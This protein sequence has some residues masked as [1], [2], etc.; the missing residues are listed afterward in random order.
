MS[1]NTVNSDPSFYKITVV[2]EDTNVNVTQGITKVV[3]VVSQGP[4]GPAGTGGGGSETDPIFAA[5]SASF[6]TTGSNTFRGA[7]IIS[8]S[9]QTTILQVHAANSEPWAFGIYNDT[10]SSTIQ[11]LAGWIDATGEAN[12]GTEVNKPLRIYTSASYNNPTLTIS[13]SGVTV[14][15]GGITGSLYG[16][17]SWATSASEAITAS[18]VPNALLQGGNGFGIPMMIGTTDAQSV[19]LETNNVNR[20]TINSSGSINIG[21]ST[22]INNNT[23]LRISK[24]TPM[25]E[26]VQ[27]IFALLVDPSIPASASTQAS[28]SS[29]GITNQLNALPNAL[30][31]SHIYFR[32]NQGST[33]SQTSKTTGAHIGIQVLDLDRGNTNYGLDFR[34]IESKS[35]NVHRNFNI[36]AQGGAP[37]YMSGSLFVGQQSVN[38]TFDATAKLH[39]KGDRLS[40]SNTVFL[41]EDSSSIASARTLMRVTNDHTASIGTHLIPISLTGTTSSYDLG[42]PTAAWRSLWVGNGT[43]YFVTGGEVSSSFSSSFVTTTDP[44]TGQPVTTEVSTVIT[45][46]VTPPTSASMKVTPAGT[47]TFDG[48][49]SI[50]SGSISASIGV[51]QSGSITFGAPIIVPTGSNV[52]TFPYSGSAEITGSLTISSS[53]TFT[54]IGPAVFSGSVSIYNLNSNA[55]TLNSD[56]YTLYS[57]D[58]SQS[59][60]W[61]SRALY[62]P[63]GQTAVNWGA[64]TL[65]DTSNNASVDWQ[66]RTLTNNAFNTTVDWNSGTLNDG[67]NLSLNWDTRTLVDPS[68][69][70]SVDWDTRTQYDTSGTSSIDWANRTLNYGVVSTVDWANRTLN[71]NS[72]TITVDWQNKVLKQAGNKSTVDWNSAYL[73]DYTNEALS[74]NWESRTLHD[75]SANSSVNWSNRVLTDNLASASIDWQSRL[76]YAN[77]GVTSHIDWSNP[78]HMQLTNITEPPDPTGYPINRVLGLDKDG[79]VYYTASFG[80]GG[81]T[82]NPGGSNTQIQYNN[83]N[84]F[85]GVPTLTYSGSLLRATGSF[86]GSLTGNLIGTA[87]IASS[88]TNLSQSLNLTG[89][90]NIHN[91]IISGTVD[92]FT[93]TLVLGKLPTLTAP[94][95]GG[96]LLQG[97]AID[98]SASNG[99]TLR[100]DTNLL[101]MSRTG[102]IGGSPILMQAGI[103]WLSA[104]N[105]ISSSGDLVPGVASING[106]QSLGQYDL[107]SPSLGWHNLY[108]SGGGVT[109]VSGSSSASIQLGPNNAITF[110]NASIPNGVSFTSSGSI[111]TGSVAI[112]SSYGLLVPANTFTVGD[113]VKIQGVFTKPN[114]A[115]ATSFLLYINTSNQ[116][117]GATQLGI[118]NTTTTR[119]NPITRTLSI[120]SPTSTTLHTTTLS[121]YNDDI[122]TGTAAVRSS[123]N[124]NWGVDQYILFA[125]QN[126]TLVDRTD[127]FRFYAKKI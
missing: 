74:V 38:A 22:N 76:L 2:T 66:N 60:D 15:A 83:N 40:G 116:L 72:N 113:I 102:F 28:M 73:N 34:L 91:G 53:G 26:S 27:S 89:S 54:N 3:E 114:A 127:T 6:A 50:I 36:Y 30:V 23:V 10:F 107:G 93:S 100:D 96:I 48:P 104:S 124:I 105:G 101:D 106:T 123:V 41:V 61:Q 69:I 80:G 31:N 118:F 20:L 75:S 64:G 103:L 86:S 84:A 33:W 71:D 51:N 58:S 95:N 117:S 59:V 70:T 122:A 4:Q 79:R 19:T 46:V 67:A 14:G 45:T 68:T 11:G 42:S 21:S 49:L 5:K 55:T 81:S 17:S 110:S 119:W 125:A 43:I 29:Y 88:V 120:E 8:G 97:P 98:L 39:I 1:D 63:A 25:T 87:S 62:Y 82:T 77:D 90:L 12:I 115:T 57:S 44:E 65:N 112:S 99:I 9:G 111:I 121:T 85:G 18:F 35:N 92:G 56:L 24:Q 7:Q 32:A 13:S 94:Q 109:F 52:V 47:F 108:I 126:A 37:N 78:L 16:T